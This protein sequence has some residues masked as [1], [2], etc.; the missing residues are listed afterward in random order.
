MRR[1]ETIPRSKKNLILLWLPSAIPKGVITHS[2][3]YTKDLLR[4]KSNYHLG[5]LNAIAKTEPQ[6]QKIRAYGP[7]SN[8]LYNRKV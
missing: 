3:K 4:I 6:L 1:V 7:R 8:K 2:C 5:G